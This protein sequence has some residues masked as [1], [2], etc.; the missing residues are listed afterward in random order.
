[1]AGISNWFACPRSK[2]K[3][4]N[5]KYKVQLP[6][7]AVMFVNEEGAL[8]MRNRGPLPYNEQAS[9]SV[10]VSIVGDALVIDSREG[11]E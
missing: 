6:L 11:E 10:G 8:T 4:L 5:R 9:E 7:T 2:S 1:M 3:T